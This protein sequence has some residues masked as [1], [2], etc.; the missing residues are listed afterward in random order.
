MNVNH[1]YESNEPLQYYRQQQLQI[2]IVFGG[3]F[4]SKV[5]VGL[6]SVTVLNHSHKVSQSIDDIQYL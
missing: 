6:F 2:F 3:L 4:Q 5:V 1:L